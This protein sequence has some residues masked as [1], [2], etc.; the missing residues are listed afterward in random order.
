VEILLEVRFMP[1]LFKSVLVSVTAFVTFSAGA[2]LAQPITDAAT[3]AAVSGKRPVIYVMPSALSTDDVAVADSSRNGREPQVA[4]TYQE[5][6]H[7]KE[8]QS[9]AENMVRQNADYFLLL[10]HGGGVGNRWAV[11]GKNGD[12]IASGQAITLGGSVKDAC[13]AIAKDW[14]GRQSAMQK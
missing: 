4:K 7:R 13:L 1:G 10:Q 5:L 3:T 14:Q 8:C 2:L 12:V 9:F 11:S 6:Q